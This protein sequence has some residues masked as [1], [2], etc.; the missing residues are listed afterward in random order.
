PAR[1]EIV[2][3]EPTVILDAAHNTASIASLLE[4]LQESF[5]AKRRILIFATS[6]DK[7]IRGMLKLLLPQFEN[8]IFSR[9]VTNPRAIAPEELASI[10]A[11][12]SSVECIVCPDP[13]GVWKAACELVTCEDL[14]CVTGSFFFAT[15]MRDEIARRPVSE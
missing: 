12:V 13:R 3:R 5:V 1:V 4:T 11:E 8:V 15:E 6:H 7:D 14:I 10:T 9:Y 2:S